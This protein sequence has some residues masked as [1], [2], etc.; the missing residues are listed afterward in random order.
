MSLR[1]DYHVFHLPLS[2]FYQ[3]MLVN[4]IDLDLTILDIL[5]IRI[6]IIILLYTW[7]MTEMSQPFPLLHYIIGLSPIIL[8]ITYVIMR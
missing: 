4:N 2:Q 1:R 5:L 6:I 8:D 7:G 3:K